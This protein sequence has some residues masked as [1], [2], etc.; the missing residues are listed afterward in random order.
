MLTI[1]GTNVVDGPLHGKDLAETQ[2]LVRFLSLNVAQT[3]QKCRYVHVWFSKS[4]AFFKN[5]TQA[6]QHFLIS[7]SNITLNLYIRIWVEQVRLRTYWI[8]VWFV[9]LALTKIGRVKW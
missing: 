3:F 8:K 5:P 9:Q 1:W 4:L 7:L 6:Q 2:Q